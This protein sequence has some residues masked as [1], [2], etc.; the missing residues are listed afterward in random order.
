M[1]RINLLDWRT[2]LRERQQK[3][4]IVLMAAGIIGGIAIIGGWLFSMDQAIARQTDRNA[5]L[6]KEIAEV[7]EKIKEIEE[8]ETLKNNLL[9]RMK[10]IEELQASR[11]ATVHFFD[12]V[13]NTLPEGVHLVALK[14]KGA[15][16]QVDG[17]AESNGR[18]STYIKN[19]EASP[20]FE[21]P[22][23]IVIKTTEQD[24]LRRGDFSLE[25]TNRT[26][27][28]QSEDEELVDDEFYE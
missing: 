6:Q 15:R 3:Q 11:S 12:E 17:V 22:R 20:W 13:V 26:I 19:L 23:L 4:F 27:P 1:T 28:S 7:D 21:N 25:V 10:V 2:E 9:A 18:I 5:M 14:Q 8:L 24:R 16:V